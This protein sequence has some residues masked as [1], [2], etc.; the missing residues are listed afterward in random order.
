MALFL[1]IVLVGFGLT[2]GLVVLIAVM[3]GIA[4]CRVTGYGR[5]KKCSTNATVKSFDWKKPNDGK[6]FFPLLMSTLLGVSAFGQSI[7][8]TMPATPL[9]TPRQSG[10]PATI[11]MVVATASTQP[12]AFPPFVYPPDM[13]SHLWI[14][15]TSTGGDWG[16][17][18]GPFQPGP[19]QGSYA[20]ARNQ[21]M[22]FFRMMEWR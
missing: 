3:L 17:L 6:W 11:P 22:Q 18:A 20:I 5:D 16:Y 10:Q 13:A 15:I 4:I 12:A 14:L 9:L 7:M 2:I 8:P 21:P 19:A 1:L